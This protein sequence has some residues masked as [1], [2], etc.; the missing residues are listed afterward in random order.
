MTPELGNTAE[1]SQAIPIALP[2]RSGLLSELLCDHT[3]S[4]VPK[5]GGADQ[6]LAP[7]ITGV[8]RGELED[9]R[10]RGGEI[11]CRGEKRGSPLRE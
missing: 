8:E 11:E 10:V 5:G 7:R 9:R 2:P 6:G 4:V 3:G 1:G